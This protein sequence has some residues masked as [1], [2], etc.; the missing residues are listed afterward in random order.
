MLSEPIRT[1]I[2]Q[3]R[4]PVQAAVRLYLGESLD[5]VLASRAP[6]ELS[7]W[8]SQAANDARRACVPFGHKTRARIV[9]RVQTATALAAP[10]VEKILFQGIDTEQ[11]QEQRERFTSKRRADRLRAGIADL[12]RAERAALIEK[13][14]AERLAAVSPV[15]PRLRS[16]LESG[17]DQ[18]WRK[19]CFTAVWESCQRDL[20][21]RADGAVI[22][23]GHPAAIEA[24]E[25]IREAYALKADTFWRDACAR[26]ALARARAAWDVCR[27]RVVL[28]WSRDNATDAIHRELL[29]KHAGKSLRARLS[30]E[31]ELA[32]FLRSAIEPISAVTGSD[33]LLGQ[34]LLCATRQL[35]ESRQRGIVSAAE[36]DGT[37]KRRAQEVKRARE[38]ARLDVVAAYAGNRM[39]RP[40]YFA[41]RVNK[42][43]IADFLGTGRK[44]AAGD[45]WALIGAL[46]GKLAE[47]DLAL[48][49]FYGRF[50][51]RLALSPYDVEQALAITK[52]E[53]LRWTSDGRLPVLRYE[54][55]HKYGRTLQVPQYD[56]LVVATLAP[57][58][59]NTWR[60]ADEEAKRAHRAAGAVKGRESAIRNAQLRDET[61][62]FVAEQRRRWAKSYDLYTAAVLELALWAMWASRWAKRNQIKAASALTKAGE[63]RRRSEAWYGRK[64]QALEALVRTPLAHVRLY[65][66]EQ[67]DRYH[68]ELC[69]QHLDEF[70]EERSYG[71][72]ERAIEFF[73][74]NKARIEQCKQCSVE[75]KR[76]YYSLYYIEVRPAGAGEEEGFSF[77]LPCEAGRE[78]LPPIH[79]TARVDHSIDEGWGTFRFGRAAQDD[80]SVTYAEKFVEGRLEAALRTVSG[81][82]DARVAANGPAQ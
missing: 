19:K 28:E 39:I 27:D 40:E 38:E 64:R 9:R 47:D 70:R 1:L 21:D 74:Q 68:V 16:F 46:C 66:P 58:M 37:R 52:T 75:V 55:V 26:V 42:E 61:R 20:A 17:L 54:S 69:S 3:F 30:S 43:D 23:E 77:H 60:A 80:E 81:Y 13:T 76:H 72:C 12:W 31:P 50:R 49:R 63:Y 33:E 2:E 29:E 8:D 51:E 56:A 45:K 36:R 78:F 32:E 48:C 25:R 57:A 11:V 59:L 65:V 34:Q 18:L 35:L 7:T 14:L 53:R 6:H 73:F 71:M 4:V 15:E 67:P 5:E 41:Q 22:L 44:R 82:L 10:D 24:L 79:E 62:R